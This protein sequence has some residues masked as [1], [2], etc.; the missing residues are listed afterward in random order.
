MTV[1]ERILLRAT[2][3]RVSEKTVLAKGQFDLTGATVEEN[4]KI[5]KEL[6]KQT[7]PI[8]NLESDSNVGGG[9]PIG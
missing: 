7:A 8:S 2:G 4:M 6:V 3:K 1:E 5:V 9:A